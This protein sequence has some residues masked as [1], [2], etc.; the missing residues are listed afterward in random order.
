MASIPPIETVSD[1]TYRAQEELLFRTAAR[2]KGLLFYRFLT[3]PLLLLGGLYYQDA[4]AQPALLWSL[5]GVLIGFN[6][7][8]LYYGFRGSDCTNRP[9]WLVTVDVVGITAL[10]SLTGGGDSHFVY[11]FLLLL[12]Y[13]AI[14][15]EPRLSWGV[16]ALSMAGVAF[17][18]LMGGRHGMEAIERP[19]LMAMALFG[20]TL[21]TA[22]IAALVSRTRD[23]MVRAT[24]DMIV[25]NKRVQD[26]QQA[27]R[28]SQER[29][30]LVLDTAAEAIVGV[31]LDGNCIFANRSCVD[32]LG[33]RSEAD[34]LGRNLHEVMHHTHPDGRPY[35]K[36]TCRV[37]VASLQGDSVHC[38]E[39]VHWRADGTSFPTEYWSHPIR[40]D[41]KVAG[42]VITFIDITERKRAEA[43]LRRAQFMVENTP[44]EVWLARTDGRMVYANEAA[45]AS[46]GYTKEEI[47]GLTIADVD[48][49]DKVDFPAVAEILKQGPLPP[50]ETVH[51]TKDGRHVPKEV[52]ATY[53]RLEGEDYVCGFVQDITARKQ[54]ESALR[55]S[56]AYNKLLFSDS[57]IPLVVL[58][59]R[60]GRYL[61]CNEAAAH[62][63]QL[64]SREA[65]LGKTPLDMSAPTQYDGS[66]SASAAR[67]RIEQALASGSH[68]FEWRHQRPNGEFWDAEVHLMSFTLGDRTLMQFSLQDITEKKR[69]AKALLES[70][71]MF[72]SV[73]EQFPGTV[74]WKDVDSV[75]L[76]CNK[77]FA[78]AAGLSQVTDIVGRTDFDLPWANIEADA[79]R[80]DDR[81]VMSGASPKL[82]IL[83]TQHQ[84]DGSTI[85][86][87]T[88]KV[89]M[90]DA[91]G[92]VIGV[93]GT[94]HD[95]TALKHAQEALHALNLELEDRV[96]QR[97]RE[98]AQSNQQLQEALSTLRHAQ[99]ELVRS[100]KLASLG[101]LVAGVAHELSTPLGNS[102]TVATT[103]AERTHHF[104]SEVASGALR[105]SALRD[106][107]QQSEQ[108]SQLLT[109]SLFQASELIS[110]FKQVAVDQT[111]AQRRPFDLAQVV[112]EMVLTL[113]P[114][115]KKTPHEVETAIPSGMRM[116]SYPGPLGQVIGN[117]VTNAL[118]HGFEGVA[119]GRVRIQAE[120]VGEASVRLTVTDNG[121]GIPA[122]HLSR[123]FDPFFTTRMGR[124]GSG[125][126]LHIV[127][128]IVTRMLGGR[129]FVT[130]HPGQGAH[131]TLE[132]PLV[133]PEQ[134]TGKLW[135]SVSVN[136]QQVQA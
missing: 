121:N 7:L 110:H 62:I 120:P 54:A 57:R 52:R 77:A 45:A 29:L 15:F 116:D 91:E 26:Q 100:E 41:G 73:L 20:L 118:V 5:I 133:A 104:A 122:E 134:T 107:V 59:P 18:Y 88:S 6:L 2:L 13:T 130:S 74:F 81:E 47:T 23:R 86:V 64:G 68:V 124:G 128:S 35:P 28:D 9:V 55:E 75:Y 102:L 32:L 72:R 132:L 36:E 12:I 79:Y 4:V 96:V 56:V 50:F 63:Y 90:F 24:M 101:S 39:E 106:F 1:S 109:R 60:T 25:A 48:A 136:P 49:A 30:R 34:L 33:Y 22:N 123:I 27:L 92:Q 93:L 37:R 40:Q 51:V 115:F 131:F 70:E 97:T 83:E 111:S 99:D 53:L 21:G 108:A 66:D 31:D 94:S 71:Q 98:L 119:A 114:Q 103:M 85:W 95:I 113:Q 61:D 84:A 125:L 117:L 42:T 126:G 89:P 19:L 112:S 8:A 3:I 129:I 80:K 14:W 46:L 65:V 69:A 17:L 135:D 127:Y 43:A 11:Y 16:G 10:A 58:D 105:R 67:Q 78:S 44:Q 38:D 82:N 87:N 76:G